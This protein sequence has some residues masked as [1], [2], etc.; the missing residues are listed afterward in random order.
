MSSK[1]Y[2]S[3]PP[4]HPGSGYNPSNY[5]P[6]RGIYGEPM[7]S[8][9]AFSYYPE[10]EKEQNF[11][12]WNSPPGI[13]KIL[14]VIIVVL[15][16][17]IFACIASTLAWDTDMTNVGGMGMGMGTGIG[18]YGGYGSGFGSGSS[19]Y[20]GYSGAGL[21][22]GGNYT[23]PRTAKGF[24]IAMA[25]ICFVAMLAV[26]IITVSR[27]NI[28]RSR[29]FYLAVI[30]FCTVLA[31]MMFIA[32]IVY[33]I[34][35]NPTAQAAGS[36]FYNQVV[37][38]C[39]QFQNPQQSGIFINQYLYHYCVVEP[40]EAIAIVFG[41][42]VTVALAIIIFFAVKTRGKI[43]KY[44]KMNINWEKE[45][46][47]VEGTANVED[48]VN[49]VTGEPGD[50]VSDYPEKFNGSM[51]MVDEEPSRVQSP[52]PKV[53]VPLSNPPPKV[54]SS[55]SED[56]STQRKPPKKRR[57]GRARKADTQGY[58]TDYTT[59]G[60]S[61]EELDNDDLESEYPPIRGDQQRQEYKRE[62]DADLQE[63]K[64]LQAEMDEIN[65]D[66]SRL[67]RELDE[68][69]EG[70][71]EYE[72]VADE[73]YLLKDKKRSADYRKKKQRCKYLKA[74]LSHIKKVVADYDRS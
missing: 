30:I 27:S 5:A 40:Q 28:G 21:G 7:G 67:D 73:F 68:L 74:K 31:V 19:S 71:Q 33:L 8:Q 56:P 72:S 57:P 44:G 42:I 3:P 54:Y 39:A 61:G 18:G 34:G 29:K 9:P 25:A 15:C 37:M 1:P 17:G 65:K 66:L 69:Q 10:D 35:V 4:Y 46:V 6:S 55:S 22:V 62:F 50:L 26:F 13:I 70:T 59:G 51:C 58:D 52:P 38:L 2:G 36:A 16:V 60:E 23:N 11:Y 45:H 48:W 24:M 49:N 53:L 14:S 47:P 20:G 41:V 32:T 64:K 63:Y 43:N 12:K